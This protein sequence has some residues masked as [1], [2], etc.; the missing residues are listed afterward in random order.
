MNGKDFGFLVQMIYES[1]LIAASSYAE[2]G[3][4][5]SLNFLD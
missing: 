3:D 2:G 5:N 1:H 4:F